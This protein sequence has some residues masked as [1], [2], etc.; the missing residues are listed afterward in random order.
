MECSLQ[1]P[2]LTRFPTKTFV[3]D[4]P[5]PRLSTNNPATTLKVHWP[6]PHPQ[7]L[8][9]TAI[10]QASL[11]IHIPTPRRR[12][13]IPATEQDSKPIPFRTSR[14]QISRPSPPHRRQMQF[15]T[16]SPHT[17]H[18]TVP[19]GEKSCKS[20]TQFIIPSKLQTPLPPSPVPSSLKVHS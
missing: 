20:T 18:R 15:K 11:D 6:R 8:I 7:G 4:A 19:Y 12:Q 16:P 1:I 10:P 2:S 5:C 14:W 13:T 9:T 17:K 3:A